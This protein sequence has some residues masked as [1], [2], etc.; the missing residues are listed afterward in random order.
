MQEPDPPAILNPASRRVLTRRDLAALPSRA[1]IA[2]DGRA[3][4]VE[5]VTPAALA[6]LVATLEARFGREARRLPA[7]LVIAAEVPF[8]E[9]L[10]G[11]VLALEPADLAALREADAID[12]ADAALWQQVDRD[13]SALGRLMLDKQILDTIGTHLRS[14]V[15]ANDQRLEN[16][17]AAR[18][19]PSNSAASGTSIAAAVRPSAPP[20]V[21]T[22]ARRIVTRASS[23]SH[24]SANLC[25]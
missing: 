25:R 5:D 22:A 21:S 4:A 15:V 17:A 8:L 13:L 3:E 2:A 24:S 16:P 9:A 12:R 10:L 20:A 14:R 7:C 19:S 6:R 1:A 23:V 18:T 11:R